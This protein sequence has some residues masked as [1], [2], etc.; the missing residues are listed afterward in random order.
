MINGNKGMFKLFQGLR[1]CRGVTPLTHLFFA[2]DSLF[3][4]EDKGRSSTN[5]RRVLKNY[6]TASGQVINDDKSGLIFSPN[7]MLRQVRLCLKVFRIKKNKGFGKYLGLPT[8]FQES[9]KDIFKGLVEN[10]LL[11]ISSWN[12]LFLSPAGRLTLI[13]SVLSNLSIFFLSVFKIPVSVTKKINSLLSHFWWAGFRAG[14]SLHWC[15]R[16]FSNLPKREGG[17]GIRNIECL[18][19][20]L[21]AKHAWRLVNNEDKSL[22]CRV[23]RERIFGRESYVQGMPIRHKGNKSWGVRSILH[24]LDFVL[25]NIAWKPGIDSNLNVWSARWVDGGMPE[26]VDLL[27]EEGFGFMKDLRIKDLCF[28]GGGWNEGMVRL[29]FKQESVDKILATPIISTRIHD[30]VFR[31]FSNDGRYTVK[32]GYGVIFEEFFNNN[33]TLKDKERLNLKKKRFCKT[34]LW[35]LPGPQMWKIL[36]W[37]IIIGSLPGLREVET[38]EHL[39]RDCDVSSRIWFGS[40]LG[41]R[42]NQN[43]SLDLGEWII[44]WITYLKG[45]KENCYGLIH[46]LATLNS[47]WLLRNNSVFRGETF[48]PKFFFKQLGTLASLVIKTLEIKNT[49]DGDGDG[50]SITNESEELENQSNCLKNGLPHFIIGPFGS[51]NRWR[52]MVDASW[53]ETGIA[54]FG[55]AVLGAEGKPLFEGMLKG[56]AES[57]LQAEA[58]GV[59]KVLEWAKAQGFLHLEVSSDCLSMLQQWGGVAH[60]HHHI[61][62]IMEEIASISTSFHCLCFSFVRRNLNKIAHS[63]AKR[64]MRDC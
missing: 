20:A 17:L 46:F 22:F 58:I 37:K 63:L 12:G 21:L 1:I 4:M 13:L 7:T 60:K 19:R 56:R 10:V 23:F 47:I 38:L 32:S 49:N 64:A 48:V 43:N 5:L 15:S 45:Q 42:T 51:C 44:S 24:G 14:R 16:L 35:K 8:D 53:D 59:L 34:T 36:L 39:F 6:C 9:K 62:G 61:K 30:E 31:P 33:G 54:A 11:R 57:P 28:N 27:L 26:P 18:N 29:I 3:F 52:I 25:Q 50:V 40:V 41:I 55:W 2:D